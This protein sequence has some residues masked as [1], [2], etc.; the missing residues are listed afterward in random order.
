ML[1]SLLIV[2][3][4]ITTT[5][6]PSIGNETFPLPDNVGMLT[7]KKIVFSNSFSSSVKHTFS[8]AGVSDYTSQMTRYV[9]I[10]L[11]GN[12]YLNGYEGKV[13]DIIF[14]ATPSGSGWYMNIMTDN[15]VTKETIRV[16]NILP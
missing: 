15:K 11:N 16:S 10:H 6:S 7:G 2:F 4:F 13:L 5:I 3:F 1:I 8:I 14:Q 9:Q 12:I